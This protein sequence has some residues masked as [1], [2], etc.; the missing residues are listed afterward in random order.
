MNCAYVDWGEGEWTG[1]D[2][3]EWPREVGAFFFCLHI[4]EALINCL[5]K[6]VG[7]V[8]EKVATYRSQKSVLSSINIKKC[9]HSTFHLMNYHI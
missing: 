4:C 9:L 5:E 2:K 7:F 6:D 3:G 8:V 1:G